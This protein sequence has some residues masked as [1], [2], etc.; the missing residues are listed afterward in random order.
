MKQR[1]ALLFIVF[2]LMLQGQESL[3]AL[4]LK[5]PFL[6]TTKQS[7][8]YFGSEDALEY[9]FKKLD[10]TIFEGEG[11]VNVVHMGG[12]HVQGGTLSHA[13]RMNLAQ[14]APELNV[15]RGFFFPQIGRASCRE[16]V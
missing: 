6:D 7:L 12:S 1:L 4:S 2:T 10:R 8:Q 16:R 5:Y 13:M 14:L 3:G 9:F 15:E 11:K